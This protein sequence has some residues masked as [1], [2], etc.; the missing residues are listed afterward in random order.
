MAD[1]AK[2]RVSPDHNLIDAFHELDIPLEENE[3]G[4]FATESNFANQQLPFKF[5]EVFASICGTTQHQ[6][7]PS[8]HLET[9]QT[10]PFEDSFLDED[11]T[12]LLLV[13]LKILDGDHN[14]F[15]YP[16]SYS[17]DS[18]DKFFSNPSLIKK[19]LRFL[20]NNPDWLESNKLKELLFAD[21]NGSSAFTMKI[22]AD[23]SRQFS[24]KTRIADFPFD[25]TILPFI[26]Q[27][28]FN[29][30]N[31]PERFQKVFDATLAIEAGHFHF[32]SSSLTDSP[33]GVYLGD[34][35]ILTARHVVESGRYLPVLTST[36]SILV[37]LFA[38]EVDRFQAAA[39]IIPIKGFENNNGL[40]LCLLHVKDP[41]SDFVPLPISTKALETGAELYTVG[42]PLQ[43]LGAQELV[44]TPGY[45][46]GE[47][48]KPYFHLNSGA[49]RPGNSGGP[50]VNDKGEVVGIAVEMNIENYY[51]P[52]ENNENC[53]YTINGS[54]YVPM[55][56]IG[57]HVFTTIESHKNKD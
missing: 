35:Y 46:R 12:K 6:A 39:E 8:W 13:A 26:D 34:G 4:I 50:V 33:S 27:Y 1:S 56:V 14:A 40:D 32:A 36:P 43:A 24:E 53:E 5:L 28:S 25:G 16:L 31:V 9:S 7:F 3:E 52:D 57:E 22:D 37:A 44:M 45:F 38:G 51:C 11:E 18:Y 54:R 49:V 48:N 17:K 23:G 30:S 2:I 29:R 47:T 19:R 10:T 42:F 55:S 21:Y 20:N 41:P 15:Q